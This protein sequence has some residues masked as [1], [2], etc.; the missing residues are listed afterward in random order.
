MPDVINDEPTS[1]DTVKKIK[2][3]LNRKQL[4]DEAGGEGYSEPPKE[5]VKE[6]PKDEPKKEVKKKKWYEF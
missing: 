5:E 2:K 4:L 6:P 3:V 1:Q